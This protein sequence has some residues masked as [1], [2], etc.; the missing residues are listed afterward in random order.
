MHI[1]VYARLKLKRKENQSMQVHFSLSLSLAANRLFC[2]LEPPAAEVRISALSSCTIAVPRWELR[3]YAKRVFETNQDAGT[4][5]RLFYHY[6]AHS[7]IDV[8]R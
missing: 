7:R 4:R 2:T 1:Y 6:N 5:K 8:Y 3:Q